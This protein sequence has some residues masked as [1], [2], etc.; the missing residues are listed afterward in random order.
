M[1]DMSNS[2][3]VTLTCT[4]CQSQTTSIGPSS[5]PAIQE[6][7]WQ[8]RES[9]Y[10]RSGGQHYCPKHHT[11]FWLAWCEEPDCWGYAG[12]D[13]TVSSPGDWDRETV[14]EHLEQATCPNGHSLVDAEEQAPGY[15]DAVDIEVGQ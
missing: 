9:D 11:A 12:G 2:L 13:V 1:Q 4:R 5:A 6:P 3:V 15:A 8:V 14:L 10:Y 7:G